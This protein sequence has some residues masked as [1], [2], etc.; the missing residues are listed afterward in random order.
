MPHR[1]VRP[2]FN[3][4][5]AETTAREFLRII[6]E[7]LLKTADKE[8]VATMMATIDVLSRV[9]MG[10]FRNLR[11][12]TQDFQ[13]MLPSVQADTLSRVRVLMTEL[14]IGT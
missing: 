14:K 6:G 13:Q 9:P 1:T 11:N 2:G 7:A 8:R 5:D 4:E 10:E 12:T 3:L